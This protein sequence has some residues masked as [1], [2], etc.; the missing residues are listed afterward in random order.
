M[1]RRTSESP[2]A[3]RRGAKC[4]DRAAGKIEPGRDRSG[5]QESGDG[6]QAEAAESEPAM[7]KR[8]ESSLDEGG[9]CSIVW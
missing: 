1:G 7:M 9:D 8:L 3:I 6:T 4:W 5:A 2:T